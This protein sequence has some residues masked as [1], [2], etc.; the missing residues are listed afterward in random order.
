MTTADLLLRLFLQIAVILT[1]SRVLGVLGRRVGQT[2]AVGEMV[3]GIVLGPSLFGALVPDAQ[4][5]LFPQT[6]TIAVGAATATVAHPSMAILYALSQLGLVLYMFLV[7]LDVDVDLLRNRA[8]RVSAIAAAGI[9]APFAI[10]VVLARSLRGDPDLFP[11]HVG[12]WH[13]ALFTA[14]AMSITAFPMLAR[15]IQE[16]GIA[17]TH[18]GTMALAAGSVNDIL[19]WCL[20]AGLLA[21]LHAQP[22]IAVLALGGGMG[23]AVVMVLLGRRAFRAFAR[24][25]ER[26][27]DV[28][29]STLLVVLLV[30][31]ASAAFTDYIGI[32]AVGGAFV[33]GLVMPRGAFAR[34]VRTQTEHLTSTLLVPLFFVYS[35]LNTRMGLLDS[36]RLWALTLLVVLCAVAGKAVACAVAA[37]AAGEGWREAAAVGSLM[38]AR[39]LM[40]LIILNIG[41]QAGLIQPAFFTMMVIMAVVTTLMAAPLFELTYARHAAR[42]AQEATRGTG[43]LH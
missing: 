41:L 39:G 28:T 29:A 3:A 16:K 10:G 23:Y 2:Q 40:E 26:D 15:I 33:A 34:L 38:N 30:L 7:G 31:M 17:R 6:A 13:A 36:P 20:L 32:H 9:V 25:V 21:S 11:P 5:W 4:Q 19:A 43:C 42:A 1:V 24:C 27:H 35:G 37:R 18:V 12:G 14:A 8:G 22:S